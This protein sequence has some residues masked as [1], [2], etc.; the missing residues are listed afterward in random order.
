[1]AR[2]LGLG[3]NTV[4]IYVDHGVQFPGGNAVNVAVLTRRLGADS[5][6]LGCTGSDELGALV[7]DSLAAEGVDI[8][9]T[10]RIDGPNPFSR[11]KHVGNDRVFAGSRPGVRGRYGLQPEDFA[12]IAGFD[13]VH[14]SVYSELDGTLATIRPHA[15]LL[16]YDYSEHWDRPAARA[17]FAFVDVAFLSAPKLGEV[18]LRS[19]LMDIV[20]AGPRLV[21]A[22]RGAAGSLACAQGRFHAEGIR[23]A[24]VVDTLGAGDGLIAGFLVDWL[25][26]RDVASALARGA[27]SAARVCEQRGAWGHETPVRPGQAGL[28]PAASAPA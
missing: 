11:I 17:T 15:R 12:Y 3:D 26:H 8:S 1:M 25:A 2:V 14:T 6:F 28:E 4:D 23:P 16:S 10:R 9:R 18:E 13:L 5:A 20:A 22:T 27:E 19:L 7:R 24:K 21:V